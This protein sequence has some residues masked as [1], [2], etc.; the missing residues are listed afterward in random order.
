MWDTKTG[1]ELFATRGHSGAV[2]C[3]AWSPDGR[4]IATGSDDYR[5]KLFDAKSGDELLT[6]EEFT[7][8]VIS[9]EWNADGR[10]LASADSY[11][12]RVW[13]ASS[14]YEEARK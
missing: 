10:K 3:V 9:I 8:P 14:A 12:V 5:V 6:L 11:S 4:R 13:D 1:R 2:R 7:S